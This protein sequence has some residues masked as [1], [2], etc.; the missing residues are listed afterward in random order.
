MGILTFFLGKVFCIL[1]FFNLFTRCEA[2]KPQTGTGKVNLSVVEPIKANDKISAIYISIKKIELKG[3]DGWTTY[4]NFDKPMQ[5]NLL[6]AEANKSYFLGEKLLPAGHYQ[7]ARLILDSRNKKHSDLTI[8]S[9][10][11]LEYKD[12]EIKPVFIPNS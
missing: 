2:E 3:P 11:Y 8:T 4:K 7:E 1:L 9:E 5:L 6:D 12:G 10:C